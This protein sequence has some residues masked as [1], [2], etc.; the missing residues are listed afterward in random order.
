[1][2]LIL[3]E[4]MH[5]QT[6][7]V[8]TTKHLLWPHPRVNL[9]TSQAVLWPQEQNSASTPLNSQALKQSNLILIFHWTQARDHFNSAAS[10][11]WFQR[12][13]ADITEITPMLNNTDNQILVFIHYHSLIYQHHPESTAISKE[14][15]STKHPLPKSSGRRQFY[16]VFLYS[17]YKS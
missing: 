2:L 1:M 16:K 4:N 6:K 10:Y 13:L 14:A 12:A 17:G 5:I 15:R 7:V 3:V 9:I 8:P 11:K